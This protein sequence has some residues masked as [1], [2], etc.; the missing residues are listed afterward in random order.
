M[1]TN[2]SLIIAGIA[3]ALTLLIAIALVIASPVTNPDA[4]VSSPESSSEQGTNAANPL[5][6][7]PAVISSCNAYTQGR[8]ELL[9]GEPATALDI[10]TT[11]RSQATIAAG[12]DDN[13]SRLGELL[14]F[15]DQP[16]YDTFATQAA[17]LSGSGFDHRPEVFTSIDTICQTVFVQELTETELEQLGCVYATEAVAVNTVRADIPGEGIVTESAI[18]DAHSALSRSSRD[19]RLLPVLDDMFTG[20]RN[21]DATATATA[22]DSLTRE[23]A[24]IMKEARA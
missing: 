12:F 13:Y 22:A 8:Y 5:Q 23:C 4:E 2:K 19:H 17:D 10:F 7:I 1:K 24:T 9:T 21:D 6:A 3:A 11:A 20:V 15:T 14:S 16:G 18:T